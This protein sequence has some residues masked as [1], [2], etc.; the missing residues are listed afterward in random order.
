[1]AT[2]RTVP[3]FEGFRVVHPLHDKAEQKCSTKGLGHIAMTRS[4]RIALAVL[5]GYLVLMTL[6][7]TY[8][9]MALAGIVR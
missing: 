1:M 4:V 7:L 3:E 8:H 6:M 5:R 9:V 2:M